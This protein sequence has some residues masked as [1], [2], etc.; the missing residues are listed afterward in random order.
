MKKEQQKT[1]Q[2]LVAERIKLLEQQREELQLEVA[3]VRDRYGIAVDSPLVELSDE[4]LTARWDGLK[5]K[6]SRLGEQLIKA[7][8]QRGRLRS[9][10]SLPDQAPVAGPSSTWKAVVEKAR[11]LAEEC[12]LSTQV[13]AAAAPAATLGPQRYQYLDDASRHLAL[14]TQGQFVCIDVTDD[15]QL[16][17]E[18]HQ[19][20]VTDL[21]EIRREHFANLYFSMWLARLECFAD[22]GLRL[23]IVME[24]PLEATPPARRSEVAQMIRDYATSGHQVILVTSDSSNAQLFSRLDVPLAD[25][26]DRES[27]RVGSPQRQPRQRRICSGLKVMRSSPKVINHRPAPPALQSRQRRCF[28]H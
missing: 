24:D 16:I 19:G 28:R 21:S 4:E 22:R 14:L 3:E 23:P 8:E 7:S 12:Q 1:Q 25:F 20:H 6:L 27:L 10:L 17:L 13:A 11:E 2:K 15:E 18:D 26:S 5:S 9:Q